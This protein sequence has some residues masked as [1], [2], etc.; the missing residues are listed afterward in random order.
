MSFDAAHEEDRPILR[1]VVAGIQS[2]KKER[3]L[4]SWNVGLGKGCY[5]V[6][7]FVA[8]GVDI[9]F[10]SRE[11]EML[12]DI[13]PLRVLGVAVGRVGGKLALTVR[14]SDKDE[15]LMLT[16]TQ[17]VHVRKRS[18]WLLGGRG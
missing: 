7:A 11:L 8:D 1:N 16:E 3:A 14:V 9:E 6:T 13:S 12:H 5:I 4:T 10:G 18:R 2:L 17:V 15:P